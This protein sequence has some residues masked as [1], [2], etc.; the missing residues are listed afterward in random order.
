MISFKTDTIKYK[1]EFGYFKELMELARYEKIRQL[2][3]ETNLF[4]VGAMRTALGDNALSVQ[5]SIFTDHD[6]YHIRI[7]YSL[8]ENPRTVKLDLPFWSLVD[9]SDLVSVVKDAIKDDLSDLILNEVFFRN[10]EKFNVADMRL[11]ARSGKTNVMVE[12]HA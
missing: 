12:E 10:S 7:D 8:N 1:H 4:L 3:E 11:K 6:E 9:G 2:E 5:T